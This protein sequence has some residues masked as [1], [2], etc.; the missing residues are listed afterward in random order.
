MALSALALLV[1]FPVLLSNNAFS[2]G[3]AP[4]TCENRYD[5]E[6]TSMAIDNGTRT[7]DPVSESDLQFVALMGDGYDVSFTL[8]TANASSMNNTSAG[9][10]WYRHTA[11]GFGNG[12][13]VEGAGPDEDISVTVHVDAPSGVPDG[14]QQNGV[15]WGSWPG[16]LYITYGVTWHSEEEQEPLQ[17]DTESAP[18]EP[19]ELPADNDV[20]EEVEDNNDRDDKEEKD[21]E[22]EGSGPEGIVHSPFIFKN[23]KTAVS[24]TRANDLIEDAPEVMPIPAAD[25]LHL[26]GTLASYHFLNGAQAPLLHILSGNWSM[27][28]NDTAVTD[29]EANLTMV[30]SD[31]LERQE[32]S[33]GNLTAVDNLDMTLAGGTVSMKSALD[34]YAGGETTRLNA[35]ITVQRL[36][37]IVI[38]L[39]GIDRLETPIYGVVD[40]VIRIEDGQ[41]KVM[42]LQFDMI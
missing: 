2:H 42:S 39:E 13:C 8:H 28:L 35:T 29:F 32:F 27:T 20:G 40:K 6:I 37:V 36:N 3:E 34:Y 25:A 19:P 15:E 41:A 24:A 7:F 21:K 14:Y 11:F 18:P 23:E 33:L 12:V 22:F 17:N 5:A 31:G 26:N 9:T 1:A 16:V 10:A 30:R 38:E 4:S